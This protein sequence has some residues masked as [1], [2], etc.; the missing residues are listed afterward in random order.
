MRKLISLLVL[1]CLTTTVLQ[2]AFL[3]KVPCT[4]KQ[5]DGTVMRKNPV[6]DEWKDASF[7]IKQLKKEIE[8]KPFK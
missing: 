8:R 5:P 4:L 3:K 6:P 1:L 2:A 7:G